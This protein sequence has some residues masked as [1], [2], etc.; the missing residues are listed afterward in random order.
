MRTES[1]RNMEH[2]HNLPGSRVL[3][4]KLERD[5]PALL[6]RLDAVQVR[7]VDAYCPVELL[8]LLPLPCQKVEGPITAGNRRSEAGAA[9]GRHGG[10]AARGGCARRL[11][12]RPHAG[13]RGGTRTRNVLD[14]WVAAG[15]RHCRTSARVYRAGWRA[16]LVPPRFPAAASACT[17]PRVGTA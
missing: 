5:S 1:G 12:R 13:H 14:D 3:D 16:P 2:L 7:R 9:S 11:R 15:R 17:W 6:D 8:V 10:T 4:C